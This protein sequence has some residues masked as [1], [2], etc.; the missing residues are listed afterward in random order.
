MGG[1]GGSVAE[2]GMERRESE[3]VGGLG[4]AK[5]TKNASR[6]DTRERCTI[7]ACTRGSIKVECSATPDHTARA[8]EREGR[9]KGIATKRES[10][11]EESFERRAALP[12][13]VFTFLHE[14]L[15]SS[16]YVI[17]EPDA[18]KSDWFFVFVSEKNIFN[19]S[20]LLSLFSPLAVL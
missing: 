18:V 12:P 14:S 9:S 2:E 1:V 20:P 10:V 4:Q 5:N 13:L 6:F 16:K 11:E 7:D 3:C 17:D 8:R 19:P 15:P